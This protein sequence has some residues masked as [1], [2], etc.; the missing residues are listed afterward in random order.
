MS[1]EL[2]GTRVA[3]LATDGVEQAELEQPWQALVD[4]G[5]RPEPIGLEPGTITAHQH[6]EPGDTKDVDV[7]RTILEQFAR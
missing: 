2:D 6:I 3:V 1:G 5:A 4:A 7:G